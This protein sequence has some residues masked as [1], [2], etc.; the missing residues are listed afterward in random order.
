MVSEETGFLLQSR[1]TTSICCD[2]VVVDT[3][4]LGYTS[5]YQPLG[6]PPAVVQLEF[7]D[8]LLEN[9]MLGLW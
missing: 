7:P 8:A 5:E 9:V 4:G 3:G 6:V 2:P 1:I